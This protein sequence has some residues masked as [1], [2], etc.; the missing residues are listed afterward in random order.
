MLSPAP[1]AVE[2]FQRTLG[3]KR[4]TIMHELFLSV[5]LVMGCVSLAPAQSDKGSGAEFFAGYSVLRSKYEAEH[6]DP[7]EQRQRREM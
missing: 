3:R 6:T 1:Q 4:I 5:L 2:L 7:F